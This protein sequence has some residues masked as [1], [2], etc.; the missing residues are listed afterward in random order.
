[1]ARKRVIAFVGAVAAVAAFCAPSAAVAVP[2]TLET[3][4]SPVAESELPG[5][6]E[7]VGLP[8]GLYSYNDGEFTPV[9]VSRVQLDI[10][11]PAP[12]ADGEVETNL[13]DFNQWSSCF[14]ANNSQEVF[15]NYAWQLLEPIQ[16]IQLKCGTG[17]WGYKHIRAGKEAVWQTQLEYL[18]TV[19]PGFFANWSW[20][21]VMSTSNDTAIYDPQYWAQ[22][23]SN[24]RCAIGVNYWLDSNGNTSLPIRGTTVW[25]TDIPG[26]GVISSYPDARPVC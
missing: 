23:Q 2:K 14:V 6:G 5:A 18:R 26:N 10:V 7:H 15:A 16:N 13:I 21:D 12:L 1:M 4:G 11:E 20:D 19:S 22:K 8:E 9:D 25:S 24:T 3:G 17:D